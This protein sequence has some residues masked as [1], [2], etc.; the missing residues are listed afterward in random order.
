MNPS[1]VRASKRERFAEYRVR[2]T[3]ASTDAR[4]NPLAL[5]VLHRS[6]VGGAEPQARS[7]GRGSGLLCL[8]LKS[9]AD[10]REAKAEPINRRD[11]HDPQPHHEQDLIGARDGLN[12]VGPKNPCK[13]QE[14]NRPKNRSYQPK[15][16]PAVDA[17]GLSP[18]PTRS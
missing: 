6:A 4:E 16:L 10:P 18:N 7:G 5:G 8:E 17:H 3:G 1:D 15:P 2:R 14:Y 13:C 12:A 11:W 9:A